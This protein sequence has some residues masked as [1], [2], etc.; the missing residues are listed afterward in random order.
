LI[1]LSD[2]SELALIGVMADHIRR[3]GTRE[4]FV[5]GAQ[6]RDILLNFHRGIDSGRATKDVDFGVMVESWQEYSALRDGLIR[7]GEFVA[8]AAEQRLRFGNM[9]VDLV[10]FGGVET[11]AGTIV[12]PR[13]GD[14]MNALGFREALTSSVPI[15][16]PG[17]VDVRVASLPTQA[18]LK[19]ITWSELQIERG[20]KDAQDFRTLAKTYCQVIGPERMLEEEVLAREP[21]D[22][23]TAGAWLLGR[24]AGRMHRTAQPFTSAVLKV[25]T[26]GIGRA[27][28]ATLVSSMGTHT[29]VNNTALAGSFRD[30]LERGLR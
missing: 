19:L 6:A 21:F 22:Y 5:V 7:T 17:N 9:P 20:S 2:S 26:T 3:C 23:E 1:D 4:F 8:T 11:V 18:L 10:P 29:L 12:W 16:L 24:D 15:L 14:E 25:L 13:D 30:G 28:F 27:N